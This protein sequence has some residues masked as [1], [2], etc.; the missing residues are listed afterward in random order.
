MKVGVVSPDSFSHKS[1]FYSSSY[2]AEYGPYR[3]QG[4]GDDGDDGEEAHEGQAVASN[5][6]QLANGEESEDHLSQQS[7]TAEGRE[8]IRMAAE[9]PTPGADN[10][11]EV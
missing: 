4:G 10:F 2:D 3:G 9:N 8:R 6:D 11:T 5:G 1:S 7:S